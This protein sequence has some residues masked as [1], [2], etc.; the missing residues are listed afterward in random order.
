MLAPDQ[1][2]EMLATTVAMRTQIDRCIPFLREVTAE[3]LSLR[4]ENVS[5]KAKLTAHPTSKISTEFYIATRGENEILKS[6]L[7]ALTRSMQQIANL[8]PDSFNSSQRAVQM[9]KT[10]LL[11][12]ILK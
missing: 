5:L 7:Q 10:A 11:I 4:A 2:D 9:A 3:V 8:D 1:L 6:K 12:P